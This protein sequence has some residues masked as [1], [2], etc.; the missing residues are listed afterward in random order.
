VIIGARRIYKSIK[1]PI[2]K[3]GISEIKSHSIST[4]DKISGSIPDC[5]DGYSAEK[6]SIRNPD[7][8]LQDFDSAFQ[9]LVIKVTDS[10]KGANRN[11]ALNSYAELSE[12]NADYK[13]NHLD[14]TAISSRVDE[15][16]ELA[17][18]EVKQNVKFLV[19]SQEGL[20]DIRS[21]NTVGI[22]V[23]SRGYNPK[24][25]IRSTS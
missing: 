24:Y 7:L 21:F 8:L 16:S 19:L 22:N 20:N 1:L 13:P 14:R 18:K 12:K 9:S 25:S 11:D 2:S 10:K 23:G 15:L 17:C 6:Y 5:P 4:P 3:A